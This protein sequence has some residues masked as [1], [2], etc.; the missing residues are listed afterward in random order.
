MVTLINP[1]AEWNKEAGIIPNLW[2]KCTQCKSYYT[3]QDTYRFR[4]QHYCVMCGSFFRPL[5]KDDKMIMPGA[6]KLPPDIIS[7]DG[8]E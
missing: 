7:E 8:D 5:D 2:H 6:W 3:C 1:W 4:C